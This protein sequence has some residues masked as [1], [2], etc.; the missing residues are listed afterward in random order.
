MHLSQEAQSMMLEKQSRLTQSQTVPFNSKLQ[1][2]VRQRTGTSPI[3]YGI[4]SVY[5]QCCYTFYRCRNRSEGHT[6]GAN[7]YSEDG[8]LVQ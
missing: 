5:E 2:Q 6:N 1:E 7:C 4:V 8:G 3:I